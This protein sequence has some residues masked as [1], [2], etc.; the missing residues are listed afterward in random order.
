LVFEL[1]PEPWLIV[2]TCPTMHTMCA[3]HEPAV[4]VTCPSGAVKPSGTVNVKSLPGAEFAAVKIQT[5]LFPVVPPATLVFIG[6]TMK[7]LAMGEY[8]SIG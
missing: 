6:S 4:S 8:I 7:L 3:S 1:H 5:K 2:I